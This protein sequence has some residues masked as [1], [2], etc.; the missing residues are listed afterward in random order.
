MDADQSTKSE[1]DAEAIE[2]IAVNALA[3]GSGISKHSGFTMNHVDGQRID[4]YCDSR[5]LDLNAR[6]NQFVQICKA[7]HLAHQHGVIHRDLKPSNILITTEGTPKLIDSSIANPI[8]EGSSENVNV[9][10]SPN[11][12]QIAEPAL[13]SEYTSPEQV[14][15]EIATTASDVYALGVILYVLTTGRHPYRFKT[16]GVSEISRAI[17]EQVPERP[18]KLTVG[19]RRPLATELDAIILTAMRKEPER[20][21]ASAEHFANDLQHFLKRLPVCAYS[22][23][24]VYRTIKFMCRHPVVFLI[25]GGFALVMVA[26]MIGTATAL[27]AVRRERNR[28]KESFHQAQEAISQLFMRVRSERIL[29]QPEL[30]PLR[31]I[32]L[33]DLQRFYEEFLTRRSGDRSL[34][35]ELA[36]ARSNVAQISSAIGSSTDAIEQFQQA[37]ILWDDL[38]AGQPNNDAYRESLART[39]SEQ[40]QLMMRVQGQGNEVLRI[41]RRAQNLLEPLVADSRSIAAEHELTNVLLRIAEIQHNRGRLEDATEN[42]Q[43]VLAVESRRN[44]NDSHA[45]DSLISMAKGHALLGQILTAQPEGVETALAEYLQAVK[46]LETVNHQHPELS[47]QALEL[48]SFLRDLCTLEQTVGKLD[49]ALAS[50]RKALEISERLESR[51]PGVLDYEECLAITYNSISDVHRHRREL[52]EAIAFAQ[53]AQTLLESLIAL[54][55]DNAYLRID[56]AKSLN[57]LGRLLKQTG[58]PEMALRSFQRAVDLY[59]SVPNLDPHGFYSLACN[60]ALS[61]PL[62]GVKNGSIDSVDVSKL[63]KGDQ[64]RRKRYGN[65]AIEILHRAFEEGLLD[66]NVLQSDIDLEPIRDRSDF[67][68]LIGEVEKKTVVRTD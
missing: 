56:L 12:M 25:G 15:G 18:S 19:I 32:L 33:Q 37:V 36:S 52:D 49:S 13:I 65:R 42:I 43:K 23:S 20:R 35:A 2:A 11:S 5:Q 39:L 7:V 67:Q 8:H 63:S 62:I 66:L 50:I 48:A 22:D 54:H 26:T 29:G 3:F 30:R 46:L 60:I 1:Y 55:S 24:T 38:V 64:L 57:S 44:V 21:Y 68:S 59:E 6:L 34:K 9:E 53:K 47:E 58:E 16:A 17:C 31:T 40:A 4:E 10:S 27:I 28:D 41:F 45:L 51:Y 14:K 61:I